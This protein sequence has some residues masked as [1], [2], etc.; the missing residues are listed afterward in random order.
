MS[1]N[2]SFLRDIR[3]LHKLTRASSL[4]FPY[5]LQYWKIYLSFA[6]IAIHVLFLP[7]PN[8]LHSRTLISTLG[9]CFHFLFL[10]KFSRFSDF[11]VK[12]CGEAISFKCFLTFPILYV[13]AHE[14]PRCLKSAWFIYYLSCYHIFAFLFLCHS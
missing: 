1:S 3:I 10:W 4:S 8:T 7:S 6:N 9:S 13:L 14:H 11:C 2:V 12:E 5:S